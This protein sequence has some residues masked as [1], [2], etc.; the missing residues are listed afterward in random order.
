MYYVLFCLAAFIQHN[1]F[2]NLLCCWKHAFLLLSNILLFLLYEYTIF[3]IY[4]VLGHM[5]CQ[6]QYFIRLLFCKYSLP[7]AFHFILLTV[8]TISF[9]CIFLVLHTTDTE[10]LLFKNWRFVAVRNCWTETTPHIEKKDLLEPQT[11]GLTCSGSE[12]SQVI[13]SD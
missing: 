4:L 2:K 13:E 9:H 7:V 11:A 10:V 6:Y 12:C 8:Q 3:F 1:Y 5:D